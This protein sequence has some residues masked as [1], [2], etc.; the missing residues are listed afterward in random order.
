M[1]LVVIQTIQELS[2]WFITNNPVIP[3]NVQCVETDTGK[4]KIG[5]GVNYLATPYTGVLIGERLIVDV[6]AEGADQF[7]EIEFNLDVGEVIEFE[8]CLNSIDGVALSTSENISTTYAV[9]LQIGPDR[10]P[11]TNGWYY[12]CH[13]Y[14]AATAKVTGNQ[15]TSIAI[16][17]G[18]SAVTSGNGGISRR[19][20]NNNQFPITASSKVVENGATISER[21]LTLSPS[22]VSALG[23]D[24][25]QPVK[26]QL[27]F[28]PGVRGF[29]KVRKKS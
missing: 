6:V 21:Y 12:R 8:F 10:A 7:P 25:A 4:I 26:V 13:Y 2:T 14:D 20:M 27:S 23:I 24:D 11:I 9:V 18:P 16:I 22:A 17:A 15:S 28:H 1:P 29:F 3:A 5:T 19:R